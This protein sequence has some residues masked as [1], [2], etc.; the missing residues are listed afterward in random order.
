MAFI[1]PTN[2]SPPSLL[3]NQQQS[4]SSKDRPP[5]FHLSTTTNLNFSPLTMMTKLQPPT[6]TP[7][8]GVNQQAPPPHGSATQDKQQR[9]DFYVN[10]G[11]AVRTLREDL[12]SLFTKDL[13]YHIY[14]Y[15]P[16]LS[17]KFQST[18]LLLR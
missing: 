10:L 2:L 17:F 14:R 9:D 8:F 12:P 16:F 5:T 18:G 13:N 7:T 1:L 4:S 15:P 6:P 11:L 3:T